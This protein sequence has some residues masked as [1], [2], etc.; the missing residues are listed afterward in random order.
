MQPKTNPVYKRGAK[1]VF[2]PFYEGCL[3][4]A[5]ILRWHFWDCSECNYKFHKMSLQDAPVVKDPSPV[6]EL[7]PK[8]LS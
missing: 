4:H 6:Y 1:N 2:C 7:P 5:V 8:V 3:D